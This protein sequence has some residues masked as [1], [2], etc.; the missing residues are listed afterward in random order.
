MKYLLDTNVYLGA[1]GSEEARARFRE[2]FFPLLPATYLSAVV[3]YE[4]LVDAEDRQTRDLVQEFTRPME[5]VGRVVAP[6]FEDWR[7][8]ADVMSAIEERDRA[9]RSKL[10]ALVNDVLIALSARRIG[11]TVVTYNGKNFRLIRRHKEF[12][13]RVLHA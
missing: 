9:W 12:L 8:A 13:L 3:F 11:A 10:P 1:S 2:T 4:L 6:T 5:R 7:Q